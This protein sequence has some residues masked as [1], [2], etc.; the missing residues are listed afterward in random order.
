MWKVAC[1]SPLCLSIIVLLL[2]HKID[3]FVLK[4]RYIEIYKSR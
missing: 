1:V 2:L 3:Y 4:F